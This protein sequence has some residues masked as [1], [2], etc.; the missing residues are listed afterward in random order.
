MSREFRYVE[1]P[2]MEQLRKQG[3]DI[4]LSE[5]DRSKFFPNLTLRN[6]FDEVIIESHL[7]DAL[8]KLNDWLTDEQVEEVINEIKRIGLRKGLIE[9]NR[10]FTNL[11]LEKTT[12]SENTR[13]GEKSPNVTIIDL[14]NPENNDFLAVNQFRVNTPGTLRDYIVPDIV[15]FINGIPI[16]VVECKY[17][18]ETEANPMEEGINQLKRY[19][20]TR[21]DVHEREGN[22]RLFYYNQIMIST[23]G[24]EARMGTITSDYDH[25]LEWKDTYPLVLDPKLS[26]Q[27]RLILGALTKNNI[28]D[29]IRNFT[30]FTETEKG[31]IKVVARYHQYRAVNKII[32][33]LLTEKTP[34]A[35]SGVIWHTQGS[36][37]SMS[38][39]FLIRKLRTID[40]LKRL[41]V[42]IV[43]DRLDLEEQLSETAGLAEKVYPVKNTKELEAELGTDTSNLVMVMTQKFLKRTKGRSVEDELPEYIEFPVLNTSEDILV[44]VDEAHR[45]Q[46]GIFGANVIA[47]LPR[48]T[49]IGFT[50]TPLITRR[51]KKKTYEIFGSYIDK[52]RIKESIADGVTRQIKYEGKAGRTRIKD[53][54]KMDIEFEDMFADKT[55][56]ELNLIKKKYGTEGNVLEAEK[57]IKGIA[58]DIVNHYFENIFDNGFKAQIVA[59]SRRAAVRYKRAIDEAVEE[60]IRSYEASENVDKERL[61]LMKFLKSVVRITWE[62]ND[63]PEWIRLAK[64]AKINLG[65]DSKNFKSKFNFKKPNTG[66][67]FLIVKDMLLTGFDAPVEQVMYIDKKMTD[68]T[69]LQAIARVNRVAK[70]KDVGYI[71]DYYGITNHLK[72]ALDAYSSED[73]QID[74]V[75]TDV[76]TELPIL[77][78]RYEQ[79]ITLFKDKEIAKI[80]DYVNYRIESAEEQLRILEECLNVLEDVKVRADFHVKFKLFLRSMDILFSK[81]AAREYIP[82]LRAFGHIH[83][84]ARHRF[85]DDSINILGAGKK[86]RRLIDNYL[87]FLGIDTRIEPVDV[88]SDTF[89]QEINKRRSSRSQASEMEHA[90][91]KHCKIYF[92]TDPVLYKRISEKL[93]LILKRFKENWDE[94]VKCLKELREEMKRGRIVAQSGLDPKKH[95]PF[96]DMLADIVY[97]NENIPEKN[98]GVLKKVIIG[99]VDDM[100]TEI[101]KVGFWDSPSKRRKLRALIDDRLISS[102]IPEVYDK[103]EKIVTDFMKLA[104]S[105]MR[106]VAA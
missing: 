37:K 65:H 2:F 97:E 96:Y 17:P 74:E 66:I 21:E 64:E 13:T 30:I 32:K 39:V 16:G 45:T 75:L 95:A 69:L 89:E 28:I 9:A 83:N 23:M 59:S 82:P 63:P 10:D 68:H 36:G 38:M 25:Y 94:Q 92:N 6:N 48:S 79:L 44:L 60:Y 42:V 29:L 27:E 55:K 93:E 5:D 104:R 72:E 91:R 8:R 88:I 73:L 78:D 87:L 47:S 15:L 102:G 101:Q 46:S 106:E 105:R 62:N 81:P 19:S 80:E 103:K 24:D 77:R 49:R 50:G 85:R 35:R 7:R 70:G 11:L 4:I 57:R 52:Y 31:K 98:Q 99:I 43:T 33:R 40:Q 1:K 34:E 61:K 26:S 67:A 51:A 20:N 76:L 71:V 22:E 54:K 56:E 53:R 58:K 100:S 86:V 14:E 41:K 18:D 90:I 84:R 3:W 12:V